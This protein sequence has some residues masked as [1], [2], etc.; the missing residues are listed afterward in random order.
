MTIPIIETKNLNLR[1][2]S[3][4][5]A[6]AMHTIMNGED[7]LL[8]FP[9]TQTPTQEQVQRMID[10]LLTHWQEKGYGLWAVEHRETGVL[11]GRCGLQYLEETDEVEVDFIIDRAFW[12]QGFA[13][14]AGLASM[15]FGFNDLGLSEIVGIVHPENIGSQRVLE[16]IGMQFSEETE[17]FGMAC[18]RYV[19]KPLL[20]FT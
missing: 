1:P 10:R 6:P 16:K 13:T 11:L 12:G 19:A 2:F 4:A 7:V 15:Q 18:Y 17:Y 9:G 20:Q 8:Y 3:Q 5:D 14:E